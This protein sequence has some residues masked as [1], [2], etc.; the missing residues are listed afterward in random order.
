MFNGPV[1]WHFPAV[2]VGSVAELEAMTNAAAQAVAAVVIEPLV[3]GAAGM[4][5]W[6]AGT[7]A[8]VRAWCD[9]TGALLIC[10]EVLTGFGRTGKMF[11]CEH[12][13]VIPDI[14]VLGKALTGGYV[15]LAVTFVTEKVFD[16]FSGVHGDATTL[17][18]GHSYSGN[19]VGCAAATASLEIFETEQV[20]DRL[21]PKIELMKSLLSNLAQHPEVRE[22]R[23]C[24]FIAAIEIHRAEGH[25]RTG[26]AVCDAARKHGLLTRPIQDTV[27]LMPPFC[28]T[29]DQ[30]EQ[31]GT[32]ISAAIDEVFR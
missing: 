21:Q 14:L 26:K 32:A 23:Q 20:L 12:E 2:Q 28:I 4:R 16:L 6:P 18:Y 5:M 29:E 31:A 22:T 13:A 17:F 3:Q 10:D 25:E 11:A 27:V 9:A 15:P 19:P 8:A 24:G 7:L 1:G 30:L